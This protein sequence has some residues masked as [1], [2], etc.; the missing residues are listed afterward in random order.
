MSAQTIARYGLVAVNS[1]DGDGRGRSRPGVGRTTGFVQTD[2]RWTGRGGSG[3][4][5]MHPLGFCVVAAGRGRDVWAMFTDAEQGRSTTCWALPRTAVAAWGGM[6]AGSSAARA[7]RLAASAGENRSRPR[8][9]WRG[10]SGCPCL[11]GDQ[12]RDGLAL[13]RRKTRGRGH[14]QP[15]HRLDPEREAAWSKAGPRVTGKKPRAARRVYTELSPAGRNALRSTG[16]TMTIEANGRVPGLPAA[17][18]ALQLR[19]TKLGESV[20]EQ[21]GALSKPR[22]SPTRDSDLVVGS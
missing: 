13:T 17:I 4:R 3:F 20:S 10:R 18:R 6:A 19:K 5:L 2:A 1:T 11:R 21:S 14:R 15:P 12:G 9:A 16:H 8:R 22:R 7:G